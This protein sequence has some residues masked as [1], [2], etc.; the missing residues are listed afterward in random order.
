MAIPD[1][2]QRTRG[3]ELVHRCPAQAEALRDFAHRQKL[4]GK[5][6]EARGHRG[7]SGD[8]E[9]AIVSVGMGGMAIR[10]NPSRRSPR[11]MRL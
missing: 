1:V 2:S 9:L 7:T 6:H 10:F 3:A 5:F 8:A 4:L 11:S